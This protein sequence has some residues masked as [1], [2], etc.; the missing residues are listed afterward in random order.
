MEKLAAE[1]P[2]WGHRKIWAMGR[3]EGWDLASPP[4]C[5]VPWP[6]GACCNPLPTRAERRQLAAAGREAFVDP[7]VRP[8]RV[9]QVDFSAF[10]TTTAGT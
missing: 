4:A 2:A 3:Y 10:E 1:C 5:T 8:N 9:R 7:P 6:A